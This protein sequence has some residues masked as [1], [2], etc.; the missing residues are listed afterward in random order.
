MYVNYT[1]T[2]YV[3]IYGHDTHIL[4]LSRKIESTQNSRLSHSNPLDASVIWPPVKAHTRLHAIILV[5]TVQ[6]QSS[7]Q[8][9]GDRSQPI[10]SVISPV[11]SYI[12]RCLNP[13]L[14][15]IHLRSLKSLLC[16]SENSDKKCI[17]GTCVYFIHKACLLSINPEVNKIGNTRARA[18]CKCIDRQ[19]IKYAGPEHG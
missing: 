8:T 14:I 7:C 6:A 1:V 5:R 17:E 16:D 15:E 19:Y 4:V 18:I 11:N 10:I 13:S 2:V 9:R 3:P 12:F